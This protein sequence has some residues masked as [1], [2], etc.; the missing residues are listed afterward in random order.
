MA[1]TLSLDEAYSGGPDTL[2]LDQAYGEPSTLQKAGEIAGDVAHETKNV[3][4]GLAASALAAIPKAAAGLVTGAADAAASVLPGYPDIKGG[5]TRH[6]VPSQ[7][8]AGKWLTRQAGDISQS[9]RDAYTPEDVARERS[10]ADLESAQA[11]AGRAGKS[12]FQRGA[13]AALDAVRTIANHPQVALSEAAEQIVPL[14]ASLLIGKGAGA[15]TRAEAAEAG[16]FIPAASKFG[17]EMEQSIRNHVSQIVARAGQQQKVAAATAFGAQ[18][19]TN[20]EDTVEQAVRAHTPQELKTLSPRFAYLT[21]KEGG[22]LSNEAAMSALVSE[23]RS[24]AAKGGFGVGFLG[25]LL[26]PGA[27]TGRVAA[28][29]GTAGSLTT[30]TAAVPAAANLAERT[31]GAD[32]NKPISAGVPEAIGKSLPTT[33]AFAAAAGGGRSAK[34]AKPTPAVDPYAPAKTPLEADLDSETGG[35]P[36]P[37]PLPSPEVARIADLDAKIAAEPNKHVKAVLAKQRKEV[38]ATVDASGAD[39]EKKAGALRLQQMAI[40]AL[41]AGDRDTHDRY[42]AEAEKLDSIAAPPATAEAGEIV[43]EVVEPAA[44]PEPQKALPPPAAIPVTPEGQA[45][46]EPRAPPQKLAIPPSDTGLTPD[47]AAAG[48]RHPAAADPRIPPPVGFDVG[49]SVGLGGGKSR[50]GKVGYISRMIPQFLDVKNRAGQMVRVP[51]HEEIAIHENAEHP[52]IADKGYDKAHDQDGNAAT[53][54]FLEQYNVDPR[55]YAN[56]LRPYMKAAELDALQNP[57]N[58]PKDLDPRPYAKPTAEIDRTHQLGER[59]PWNKLHAGAKVMAARVAAREANLKEHTDGEHSNA[60]EPASERVSGERAVPKEAAEGSGEATEQRGATAPTGE[61]ADATGTGKESGGEEHSGT[62]QGAELRQDQGEAREGDG[63]RAGSSDSNAQSPRGRKPGGVQTRRSVTRVNFDTPDGRNF[64]KTFKDGTGEHYVYRDTEKAAADAPAEHSESDPAVKASSTVKA[65]RALSVQSENLE[66]RLEEVAGKRSR[67]GL[68]AVKSVNEAKLIPQLKERKGFCYSASAGPAAA[69]LGDM[70]IGHIND[71]TGERIWHAVVKLPGGVIF[72]RT[73]GRSFA[74][75]VYEKAFEFTPKRSLTPKAVRDFLAAND[76]H[77]PDAENLGLER[78][79]ETNAGDMNATDTRTVRSRGEPDTPVASPE[80]AEPGRDEGGGSAAGKGSAEA[81]NAGAKSDDLSRMSLDKLRS[82]ARGWG[83]KDIANRTH[84]SLADEIRSK[85]GPASDTPAFKRDATVRSGMLPET[86]NR[87]VKV[88][89]QHW[90]NAPNIR[91]IRSMDEASPRVREEYLKQQAAGAKGE[92]VAWYHDGELTI[93]AS[94]MR[95]TRHVIQSL[96]HEALGHHGL[97]SVFGEDFHGI[98]DSVAKL[99]EANVRAA[100][101]DYGLDYDNVT[102]RRR[103]AEEVLAK[104]AETNPKSPLVVRA[105]AAIRT[106]LRKYVPGFG[107]MK[108]SNDELIRNFIVPARRFVESGMKRESLSERPAF[109][110]SVAPAPTSIKNETT[111]RERSERGIAPAEQAASRD[112]GTVWDEAKATPYHEQVSLIESLKRNPRPITDKEDAILLHQQIGLQNA[113]DA[114]NK[115]VIKA[116]SD[117]DMSALAERRADAARILDELADLYDVNR[118][119][120]TENA[121]GL[122]ARKIL[123][124][125]DYSLA[126]MTS[127]MREAVGGRKL[128]EPEAKKVEDAQEKIKEAQKAE[129]AHADKA[130]PAEEVNRRKLETEHDKLVT[131]LPESENKVGTAA[132]IIRN[133][134]RAGDTPEEAMVSADDAGATPDDIDAGY[135]RVRERQRDLNLPEPKP[136]K[137]T[138]LDS[139]KNRLRARIADL[140]RQLDAG[141]KNPP[142]GRNKME[143][144]AEAAALKSERDRLSAEFHHVFKEPMSDEQRLSLVK[145]SAIKRALDYEARTAARDFAIKQRKSVPLD[146]EALKLKAKTADAKLAFDRAA[147]MER[148]NSRSQPERLIDLIPKWERMSLLSSPATLGKLFFAAASRVALA[149]AREGIGATWGVIPG[150]KQIAKGAPREG[151]LNLTAEGKALSSLLTTGL[152]DA[153]QTL[154]HGHSDLDVLYGGKRDIMPFEKYM[155]F[156]GRVHGAEKSPVKRAEFERSLEKRTTYAAANG[157]DVTDPMVQMRLGVEAYK[158]ARR[159]VFMQDNWLSTAFERAVRSLDPDQAKDKVGRLGRATAQA[160]VRTLLPITKVPTN[161][162]FEVIHHIFGLGEAGVR[163]GH[164]VAKGLKEATPEEND[165]FMRA[166]KDGT[167][168]AIGLTVGYLFA[169]QIGGF[170]NRQDKS[171]DH[172]DFNTLKIGD[173]KVP[174]LALHNPA[175]ETLQ[176]GATIRHVQDQITHGSKNGPLLAAFAA[177]MGLI[178]QIPFADQMLAISALRDDP[179]KALRTGVANRIVPAGLQFAA[180]QV[181]TDSSGDTVK[182]DPKTFQQAVEAGIPGLREDVPRKAAK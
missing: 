150:I 5:V 168:G 111:D 157:V 32:P 54:N 151:G 129:D 162:A 130:I 167:V 144:D 69:G 56:A 43:P 87:V 177:G 52:N 126:A 8:S 97:Q 90:R 77:A 58:V 4:G 59:H 152:Q 70:V 100:A 68:T 121:R 28:A 30:Q 78:G 133:R 136:A 63:G 16:K 140:Q 81:G 104:L 172:P 116:Y 125:Q 96:F 57:E 82:Y 46:A 135:K 132:K 2:S 15:A 131:E 171:K 72:D 48:A 65:D 29:A 114:A 44:E 169:N 118:A 160:A 88:I 170:W 139:Y 92:P 163:L 158:D 93:N 39:V 138:L 83:L 40:D 25:G 89:T 60:A 34:P 109:S 127:R 86:V 7:T 12:A 76:H 9:V 14:A 73:M 71:G 26:L 53:A 3:A 79:S 22:G 55:S 120:G 11:A 75:G 148:L 6:F 85:R 166:L 102:D 91:I 175:L 112:F 105:M 124:N 37:P 24:E 161:V 51:V 20:A 31:S 23:A 142:K 64:Y 33:A 95:D 110:R 147:M 66:R 42:M 62:P 176:M 49:K 19:A 145:K 153:K 156:F 17:P 159:A 80:A 27:E 182:R 13:G 179:E 141:E 94:A 101:K 1:D 128:T 107:G 50:N 21:S 99:N 123:A 173:H 38:Q 106:W 67:L 61:V 119:A 143:L 10:Q 84:E 154:L 36:P 164:I 45:Q 149:P 165:L 181:D 74:P 41:K 117:G 98:L 146:A 113:H 137:Q 35:E 18:T 134:I 122:N 47:V 178:E 155:G 103:A 108:F 180:K 115:A 174:A